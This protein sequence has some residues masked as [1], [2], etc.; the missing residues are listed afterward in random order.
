M[1]FATAHLWPMPPC[2]RAACCADANFVT[3]TDPL[4]SLARQLP[5]GT[6]GQMVGKRQGPLTPGASSL[7]RYAN[8]LIAYQ[9]NYGAHW[10]CEPGSAVPGLRRAVCRVVGG[11]GRPGAAAGSRAAAAQLHVCTGG[12]CR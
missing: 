9:P 1:I 6:T 11:G 4:R 3:F 8:G 12:S 5:F 2:L 7:Q 10:I